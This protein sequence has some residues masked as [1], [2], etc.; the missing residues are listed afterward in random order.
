MHEPTSSQKLKHKEPHLHKG[1]FIHKQTKK[2]RKTKTT[3]AS[4]KV[5][6]K[7]SCISA[8]L[9]PSVLKSAEMFLQQDS[10]SL[11]DILSFGE[12]PILFRCFCTF[13][14]VFQCS[15]E[16]LRR[17]FSENMRT[18]A[19]REKS[20][21]SIF[22]VLNLFSSCESSTISPRSNPAAF[23]GWFDHVG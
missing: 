14:S 12:W 18:F 11:V 7:I 19:I 10:N 2:T 22:P 16:I 20:Q 4:T 1:T 9:A 15:L 23:F 13:F 5:P 17:H 3:N 21:S 6:V 8:G